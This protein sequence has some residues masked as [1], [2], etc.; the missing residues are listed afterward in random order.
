MGKASRRKWEKRKTWTLERKL[1]L[2]VF[3]QHRA[4]VNQLLDNA[5]LTSRA[6]PSAAG[7]SKEIK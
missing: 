2:H 5:A 6:A 7:E 4:L 3:K 1:N